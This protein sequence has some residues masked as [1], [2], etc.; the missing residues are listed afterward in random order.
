[1][2]RQLKDTVLLLILFLLLLA[3]L[4]LLVLALWPSSSR[5]IPVSSGGMEVY[6]CPQED[7]AA[8]L[9]GLVSSASSVSCALYE[10]KDPALAALLSEGTVVVDEDA[11]SLPGV[12]VRKG[13][14]LMHDKVC[15]ING[16]IVVT[17]SFNPV[18]YGEDYNNLVVIR[19]P[20]MAEQYGRTVQGIVDGRRRLSRETLFLHDGV[21]LEAYA[22]PQDDCQKHLLAALAAANT[23]LSFALFTFTDPAVAQAL[24]DAHRRGVVVTGVVESYQAATY[25]KHPL[26]QEAGIDVVLERSSRLQHNK[27]FVIDGSIVVT[28]SYNPTKAA[29]TINDENI[30]VIHDIAFARRYDEEIARIRAAVSTG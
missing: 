22:C 21:L 16:S 3:C 4:L 11:P 26:L 19:S 20:T 12:V 25:A 9:R 17:G 6:F 28:G 23:S 10:L 29:Y 15:V 24:I 27:V 30:L 18:P 2:R 5:G 14:G 13:E 8:V 1:M 7:C